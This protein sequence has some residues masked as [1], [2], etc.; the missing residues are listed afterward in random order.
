MN[1]FNLPSMGNKKTRAKIRHAIGFAEMFL[2]EDKPSNLSRNL[3]ND[4]LGRSN[5]EL[6]K[7]LRQHV[8]ICV[9]ERYSKDTGLTKAY[10]KNTEGVGYLKR[11][12]VNEDIKTNPNCTIDSVKKE[13]IGEYVKTEWSEQLISGRFEYTA[14]SERLHHSLQ[15]L[16]K[17]IRSEILAAHG[18]IYDYDIEAATITLLHQLAR[19]RGMI[20][21]TPFIDRLLDD[22]RAFRQQIC[23]ELEIDMA[24]AKE[25]ISALVNGAKVG[26]TNHHIKFCVYDILGSDA[27]KVKAITGIDDI[28]PNELIRGFRSDIKAIWASLKGLTPISRVKTTKGWR[29]KPMS[30]SDKAFIYRKYE[31]IV[32]DVVSDYLTRLLEVKHFRIHDGFTSCEEIDE[33]ELSDW[34]FNKTGFRVK[35]SCDLLES[36]S[37]AI[38]TDDSIDVSVVS[39]S[40]PLNDTSITSQNKLLNKDTA[41]LLHY[42]VQQLLSTRK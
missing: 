40:T 25:L 2:R 12:L 15:N 24:S 36:P 22:K 33:S 37:S 14:K 35:F 32:M 20:V 23:D 38:A 13:I 3:I 1:N 9:D 41:T 27:S 17:A 29:N 8:L 10:V 6:G 31:T 21:D 5:N 42:S 16:P 11:L 34:V 28:A 18:Y 19:S 39:V 30:S 7:F 26:I 4:R